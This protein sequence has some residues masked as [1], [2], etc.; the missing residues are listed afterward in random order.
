MDEARLA[1]LNRLLDSP[2]PSGDEQ[3]AARIWREEA[4]TFADDVSSDVS[5]NSYAV[6]NGGAT[7]ILLA[8]HID[9]IGIMVSYIDEDGYLYFQPIGGWD[10]QVLVGQRVRLLGTQGFVIG[11]IGKKPIHL[12]TGDDRNAAT[13]IESLWI[14]I[15]ATNRSEAEERVQI[16]CSGVLD[17]PLHAFPNGRIVSRSLDNRIGAFTVL[18]ALR[19]LAQDRPSVSVAAVATTHEEISLGGARIAAY[20]YHPYAAIVVDV[21]Y[22][23]D[24]PESNKRQDG[25]VRLG[26]GPVLS[27]GSANHPL[28]YARLVETA[29]RLAI[30]FSV[31]IT[32]RS[33]GT[34]ADAMYY[35]R[36]GVAT[37]VVSIPNRYM[38][39]P[40]EMIAFS[41]VEH[42]ARLIAEFVKS[43]QSTREFVQE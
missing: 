7:R 5:G 20:N 10:T 22:A 4:R 40:N 38:H 24:H 3:A 2:G 9:E 15:G 11:V 21:T 18:E 27:R 6:L 34:D 30:P 25:D 29:R 36:N 26:G 33:T 32:P 31:Q 14:D 37:G 19:L 28:V 23:T 16:G 39:S 42:A 8:G 35:M 41:D 1:F 17:V 13:K 12:I 43:V